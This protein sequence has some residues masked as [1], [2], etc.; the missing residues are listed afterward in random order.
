ML[1]DVCHQEFKPP[2]FVFTSVNAKIMYKCYIYIQKYWIH[3]KLRV[4]T[5]AQHNTN[6]IS[7]GFI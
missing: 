5:K 7:Q 3:N 1:L 4:Y 6:Q 2:P